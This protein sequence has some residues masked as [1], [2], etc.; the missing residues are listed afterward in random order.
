MLIEEPAPRDEPGMWSD[1]WP[2][3]ARTISL[4]AP[5]EP[6]RRSFLD[7]LQSRQSSIGGRVHIQEIADLLWFAMAPTPVGMGRA[8]MPV[9]HRPYPSFGG[10]CCVRVLIVCRDD[11][12]VALYEPMAHRLDVIDV[13]SL[14]AENDKDVALVLGHTAGCTLRFVGDLGKAQAAYT[15]PETL[16]LREAGGLSATI[17]LCAEW[18]GLRSCPLGSMGTSI[19]KLLGD[20]H[21]L[22]GL[23][24]IQ[25]SGE[26][27]GG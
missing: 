13:P 16:L 8:G 2:P 15:A 20:S 26:A 24:G 7:V 11:Q 10:L 3:A 23:G 1:C 9:E 14:A 17:G 27:M 12:L 19:C 4:P 22:V 6:P 5:I 21:G 25:I 18:L